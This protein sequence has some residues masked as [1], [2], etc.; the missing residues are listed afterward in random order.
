MLIVIITLVLILWN[1]KKLKKKGMLFYQKYKWLLSVELAVILVLTAFNFLNP[2]VM[3]KEKNPHTYITV[4]SQVVREGNTYIYLTS[5]WEEGKGGYDP[6][7][8]GAIKEKKNIVKIEDVGFT[9]VRVLDNGVEEEF[10]YGLGSGFSYSS[11]NSCKC[12]TP[13]VFERSLTG[14]IKLVILGSFVLDFLMIIFIKNKN[15]VI[16]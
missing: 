9:K 4:K 15:T 6:S 1:S 7:A 11:P 2:A 3:I 13:V 12:G 14:F 8:I 10:G 16:E 5:E